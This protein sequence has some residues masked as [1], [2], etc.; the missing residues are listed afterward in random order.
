MKPSFY[1]SLSL[2]LVLAV[3]GVVSPERGLASN[4]ENPAKRVKLNIPSVPDVPLP[5]SIFNVPSQPSEGRNPFFPQSTVRV[6]VPTK[7]SRENPVDTTLFVLNGIT[8]PP[9]RTAMIN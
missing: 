3:C 2:G 6:V 8:S 5:Q 7:L 1:S 4:K 9:K